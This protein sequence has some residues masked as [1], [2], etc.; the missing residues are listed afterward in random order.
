MALNS[1][2]NEVIAEIKLVEIWSDHPCLYDVCSADFK[3]RDKRQKA[4]QEIAMAVNQN[5]NIY[6]NDLNI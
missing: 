4:L 3:D 5:S 6:S 2:L 1:V